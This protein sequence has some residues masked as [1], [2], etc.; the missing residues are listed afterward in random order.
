M[1][2]MPELLPKGELKREGEKNNKSENWIGELKKGSWIGKLN[3]KINSGNWIGK[4]KG[5]FNREIKDG[6]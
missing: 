5:K 6:N 2:R 1:A 3:R 4:W